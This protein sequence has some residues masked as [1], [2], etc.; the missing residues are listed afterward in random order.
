MA[1]SA[2]LVFLRLIYFGLQVGND[3]HKQVV[4]RADQL[5][6]WSTE[7]LQ[8]FRRLKTLTVE[9]PSVTTKLKSYLVQSQLDVHRFI[10]RSIRFIR[11]D[12]LQKPTA[13]KIAPNI[14]ALV[15][16]RQQAVVE[17]REVDKNLGS[18]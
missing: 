15:I 16:P 18:A 11:Q 1:S 12:R 2:F 17:L 14:E 6:G 13:A 7:I 9:L 10:S 5:Y 8:K 4:V 3:F